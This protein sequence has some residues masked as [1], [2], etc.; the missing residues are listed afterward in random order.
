MGRL[1]DWIE[2]HFVR[3]LGVMSVLLVV[4]CLSLVFFNLSLRAS[5]R[6]TTVS[7]AV[8][9]AEDTIHQFKTLRAYYT[10]HVVREA[11]ESGLA[12]HFEHR[13]RG[14]TIPLPATM[15]HDLSDAFSVEENG[16]RIRLYSA[17]PFPNRRDRRLDVFGRDALAAVEREPSDTFIHEDLTPGAERIRVAIADRMQVDTC[18]RCHNTHPDSPRTDWQLGD[19]R[20]VLEVDLPIHAAMAENRALLA[21]ASWLS[22]VV[23]VFMVLSLLGAVLLRQAL[24]ARSEAMLSVVRSAAEGDLTRRLEVQGTGALGQ[25]SEQLGHCL[26]RMRDSLG[27]IGGNAQGL[28]VASEELTSVS[29]EM[30]RNAE[31]TAN[32]VAAVSEA[33]GDVDRCIQT[34]ASAA[35]EMGES[36][37]SVESGT[38]QA[39]AVASGAVDVARQTN[40]TVARLGQS[41]VDIGKVVSLITSIAEQTNL[42]ALNATIEAARAGEAG[43]GFAVVAT[44]VKELAK[45][46]SDATDEIG[47]K[48][49]VI[50][51][52]TAEAIR[53]IDDI[54]SII[55]RIH[56]IQ[57]GITKAVTKQTAAS[58]EIDRSVTRAAEGSSEIARSMTDVAGVA[59]S[60]NHGST[61]TLQA[62]QE[63]ASMAAR[64]QALLSRYTWSEEE[65]LATRP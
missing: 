27:D 62:A 25:V 60:T 46:T 65:A 52:D 56:D 59:E 5:M 21:R 4:A 22:L 12:I 36:I 14:G 61:E 33:A 50:Q 45:Q 10:D 16:A 40:A 58:R 17:H 41:S 47:R 51:S 48:I 15:V 57:V 23:G 7:S 64:L 9:K 35:R 37:Q 18:V 29:Q 26:G 31:L 3:A 49:E 34:A 8:A 38:K 1:R 20:G 2:D 13:D 30:G 43:K 44:E 6:R 39:T 53:A 42:L 19:V 54:G 11:R 24:R 63:L 32:R 55:T 28:A